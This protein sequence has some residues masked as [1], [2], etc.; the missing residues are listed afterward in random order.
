MTR[1]TVLNYLTKP[2]HR[3]DT[4]TL[5]Q[6]LTTLRAAGPDRKRALELHRRTQP[7][8]VASADVGCKARVRAAGCVAW[9]MGPQRTLALPQRHRGRS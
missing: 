3:R 5:E 2:G 1:N 6:L 4:R 8:R 9:P 7:A